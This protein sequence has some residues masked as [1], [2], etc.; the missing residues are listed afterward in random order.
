[1]LADAD[2]PREALDALAPAGAEPTSPGA[3]ALAAHLAWD[4]GDA[5][6]AARH[7][8]HAL[9][10]RPDDD[11]TSTLL[12]RALGS[13]GHDL[14]AQMVLEGRSVDTDGV[15]IPGRYGSPACGLRA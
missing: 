6:G 12:A 11:A 7:A 10:R 15:A 14:A 9:R 13:L 3:L 5:A 1:M 4:L 8:Q 2:R